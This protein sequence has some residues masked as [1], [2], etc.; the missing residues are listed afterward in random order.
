[1]TSECSRVEVLLVEDN[2]ADVRLTMEALR[3]GKMAPKLSVVS[4]GVEAMAFLQRQNQYKNAPRPDIILLDLNLP[5][6]SGL[7]VLQEIKTSPEFQNIPVIILTTSH[8]EGDVLKTY[9][10]HANC[11][12]TKPVD[13]NQFVQVVH[14]IEN[15]WLTL[16]K[17]PSR[18]A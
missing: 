15:F 2:P 1:M 14:M 4:D 11:Y 16:V 6:K 10:H 8:A 7:E 12:L 17:L 9:E 18:T 13:F 3:E 5:R